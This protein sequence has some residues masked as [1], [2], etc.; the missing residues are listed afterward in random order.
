MPRGKL[1]FA[2]V[3]VSQKKITGIIRAACPILFSLLR[4][5]EKTAL[6]NWSIKSRIS[7]RTWRACIRLRKN[8]SFYFV[9]LYQLS[10]KS[11]ILFVIKKYANELFTT[12]SLILIQ[13]KIL[14]IYVSNL[15][16]I[17]K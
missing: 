4:R 13:R 14:E 17:K 11:I 10:V 16:A 6:L 2:R 15:F 5:A 9:R 12:L 3:I 7:T 8:L 1:V